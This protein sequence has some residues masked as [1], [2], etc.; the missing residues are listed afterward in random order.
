MK[1]VYEGPGQSVTVC[2]GAQIVYNKDVPFEA[3]GEYAQHLLNKLRPHRFAVVEA[4]P[5]PTAEV[6]PRKRV[7]RKPKE[8]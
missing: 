4:D 7:G 3:Y 5:E 6:T 8:I 1:L 2:I